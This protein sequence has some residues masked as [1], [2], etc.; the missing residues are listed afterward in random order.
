MARA[1]LRSRAGCEP[2]DVA[3]RVP[4]TVRGTEQLHAEGNSGF[5]TTDHALRHA[6]C[7]ALESARQLM[8]GQILML[9]LQQGL[10]KTSLRLLPL[11]RVYMK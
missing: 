8:L 3:L 7:D 4:R 9:V 11:I 6:L 2:G 1:A 10:R 5:P